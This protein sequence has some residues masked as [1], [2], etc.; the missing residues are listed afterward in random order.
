MRIPLH[1]LKELERV[2]EERPYLQ[3]PIYA[4]KRGERRIEEVEVEEASDEEGST[5]GGVIVIDI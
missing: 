3:L 2:E 5:N 1:L 4:P